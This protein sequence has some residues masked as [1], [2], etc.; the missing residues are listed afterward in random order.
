M[1]FRGYCDVYWIFDTNEV[2]PTSGYVFTLPR[3]A[4][5][6]LEPNSVQSMRKEPLK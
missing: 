3:G 5:S 6:Y 2:K 1:I 4:V